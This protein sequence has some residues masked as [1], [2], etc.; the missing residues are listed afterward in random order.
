MRWQRF[1]TI[2]AGIFLC[3]EAIECLFCLFAPCR[4]ERYPNTSRSPFG[5]KRPGLQQRVAVRLSRVVAVHA[6]AVPC[7]RA[8]D[9]LWP[10]LPTHER[11]TKVDAHEELP[12]KNCLLSYIDPNI[13]FQYIK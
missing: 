6:S 5:R 7:V 11:R 4:I 13:F 3:P 8:K 10:L 9:G 1:R 2:P 12:V